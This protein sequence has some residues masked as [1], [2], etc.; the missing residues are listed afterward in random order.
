MRNATKTLFEKCEMFR[1]KLALFVFR[2]SVTF[3][4]FV[5]KNV[6]FLS[7]SIKSGPKE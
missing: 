2:Q 3:A 6:C 4:G 1:E 5:L 7:T